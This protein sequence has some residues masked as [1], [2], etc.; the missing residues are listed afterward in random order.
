[1]RRAHALPAAALS[2]VL[3]LVALPLAV[4]RAPQ[5][6]AAADPLTARTI[7]DLV[8]V[9][10]TPP[11]A[12][13]AADAAFLAADVTVPS[14]CR[15]V[16]VT[17]VSD[18]TGRLDREANGAWAAL[19]GGTSITAASEVSFVLAVAGGDTINFRLHSGGVVSRFLLEEL[20]Q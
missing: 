10:G 15:R 2:L 7:S 13:F 5:A 11:T 4:L 17:V 3:G 18:T 8:G 9:T 19:N 1:M 6:Q 16:V 20:S 12:T 14:W